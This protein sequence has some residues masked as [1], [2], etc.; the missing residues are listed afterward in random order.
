MV[1]A[2]ATPFRVAVEA[3]VIDEVLDTVRAYRWERLADAGG[4]SAGTSVSALRA[5]CQTWTE[6]FDWR[7]VEARVNGLPNFHAEIAGRRLHFLHVKGS[8]PRAL[9]LTH[10]WPGSFLEFLDVIEPLAHPE[11][12]GGDPADGFD[13]IVP[14]LPGY[15][16]SDAPAAPMGPRAVAKT[17]HH[18]MTEVLGYRRFIAQGGDW[19][20]AISGWMAHDFPAACAGVHLN[21]A[22]VQ[23]AGLAAETDAERAY[24]A[25]R[26]QTRERESAYAHLQATRPQTLAFAMVDNPVGVAGWMLEKFAAWSD[27]PRADGAP[28]MPPAL[29]DKALANIM[30]YA[31]TN[32]FQTSTWIYKGR[33][34]EGGVSFAADA[35]IETPTGIAAFPDP[36]FRMPPRSMVARSY[37]VVHWSDMDAGGHFA[38]MEA[39]SAFAADVRAFARGLSAV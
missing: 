36:V 9:L 23:R 7:A 22:L 5:L 14:S 15:A 39:P 34:D 26:E 32:S 30:L 21:M 35:F 38:A 11:R 16:F 33:I 17:L 2:G 19:G 31:V 12:F 28:A 6:D 37:N 8:A 4:W 13:V 10:G 18:L 29:R 3:S 20:S 25:R 1:M 24:V 27:I